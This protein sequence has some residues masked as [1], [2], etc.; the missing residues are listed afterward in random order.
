MD[1][2][3][4]KVTIIVEDDET[5]ETLVF[6]K[7]TNVTY[8]ET[9]DVI[10]EKDTKPTKVIKTIY[11]HKYSFSFEAIALSKEGYVCTSTITYKQQEQ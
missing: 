10:Y 3:Y 6:H 1:N 9:I 2:R 5:I 11:N 4:A 8:F 7:T